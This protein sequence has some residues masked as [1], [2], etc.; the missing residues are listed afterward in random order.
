MD[1]KILSVN[2]NLFVDAK[3]RHQAARGARVFAASWIYFM[4]VIIVFEIAF[5]KF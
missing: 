2:F 1:N 3:S 4:L 5:R